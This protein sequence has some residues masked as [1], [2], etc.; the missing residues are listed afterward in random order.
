MLI[1]LI[2]KK[3]MQRVG[4]FLLWSCNVLNISITDFTV[5][6]AIELWK[7]YFHLVPVSVF[8]G[9]IITTQV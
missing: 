3:E 1:K 5:D 2:G 6:I 8:Y 7:C 9:E 4:I